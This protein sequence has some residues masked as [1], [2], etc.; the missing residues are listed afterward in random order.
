MTHI[1]ISKLTIIGPDNGLPPGRHQAI[2]W[3]NDGIL[4]I[5]SLGIHFSEILIKFIH[6]HSRKR[7]W[8][9]SLQKWRPFC[10]SLNV[11]ILQ[12]LQDRAL[13]DPVAITIWFIFL[14]IQ[15]EQE[16]FL[17]H[18][19]VI[20]M[21]FKTFHWSIYKWYKEIYWIE[22]NKFQVRCVISKFSGDRNKTFL[23]KTRILWCAVINSW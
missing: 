18:K 3:T 21:G 12:Y 20:I 9:R 22:I 7:I 4:L 14:T 13:T 23:L 17:V 15:K 11:I 10:L 19:T 16:T 8:K 6:Y 1:C 5:G 2:I